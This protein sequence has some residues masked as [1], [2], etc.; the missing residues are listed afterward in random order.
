MRKIKRNI[1]FIIIAIAFIFVVVFYYYGNI[2]GKLFLGLLASIASI[3]LGI[4][5]YKIENDKIFKE[6]F[7]DFNNKYDLKFND[8][9]N[10]LKSDKKRELNQTEINL[11]IDY[12]NLCAEEFLWRQKGRIPKNV[13]TAWHSGILENIK[14]KQVM[15]L[16]KNEI[17][18]ENGRK[19]YYGLIEELGF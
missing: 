10:E 16:L 13:W 8:L 18:T 3:Y 1:E 11:V 14:I 12:L 17:I 5:K 4:L 6:L 15:E 19:S 7:T 9:I 2:D